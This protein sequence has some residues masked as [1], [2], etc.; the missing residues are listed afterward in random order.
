MFRLPYPIADQISFFCKEGGRDCLS[1]SAL[2]LS[3]MISVYKYVL[4]RIL[5]FVS[6]PFFFILTDYASL[7]RAICKKERIS[8]IC[9]GIA[10]HGLT[11]QMQILF[12]IHSLS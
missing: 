1:F 4:Q 10:W 3:V 2:A 6:V 9:F 12:V 11:R 8:V 5:N 7:R